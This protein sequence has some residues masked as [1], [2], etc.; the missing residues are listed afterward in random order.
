MAG[1]PEGMESWK[2]MWRDFQREIDTMIV[3]KLLKFARRRRG[4]R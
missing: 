2:E 1:F 3:K 4:K